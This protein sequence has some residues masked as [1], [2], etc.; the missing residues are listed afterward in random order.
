[1]RT[2]LGVVNF[3]KELENCELIETKR[4]LLMDLM[5]NF[6]R[7]LNSAIDCAANCLFLFVFE[8]IKLFVSI[9][10]G[11]HYRVAMLNVI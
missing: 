6:L 5:K 9:L 8:D 1:M 2:L 11:K 4:M 7:L 3:V 10:L